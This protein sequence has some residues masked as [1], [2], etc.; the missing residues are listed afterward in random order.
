VFVDVSLMLG[1][2]EFVM[3]HCGNTHHW[4]TYL[5]DAAAGVLSEVFTTVCINARNLILVS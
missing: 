5:W 2:K 4:L 1:N 3:T